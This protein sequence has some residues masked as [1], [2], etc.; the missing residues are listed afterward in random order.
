MENRNVSLKSDSW[1]T[2][3]ILTWGS[4]ALQG[5]LGPDPTSEWSLMTLTLNSDG[6]QGSLTLPGTFQEPSFYLPD[7]HVVSKEDFHW[8]CRF[9]Q[10]FWLLLSLYWPHLLLHL[11]LPLLRSGQSHLYRASLHHQYPGFCSS[12][13]HLCLW[14][15]HWESYWWPCHLEV[16]NITVKVWT[17]QAAAFP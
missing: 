8:R 13:Q 11:F 5:P 9:L 17:C 3:R 4:A 1:P 14:Q 6:T 16:R 10:G 7:W 15:V 12:C 2:F